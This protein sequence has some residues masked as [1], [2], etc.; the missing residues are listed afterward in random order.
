[1]TKEEAKQAL[2]N[3][4]KITHIWFT[5][6]EYIYKKDGKLLDEQEIELNEGMFWHFRKSESWNENYSIYTK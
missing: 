1:M 2:N 5:S 4:H 6:N 3:G